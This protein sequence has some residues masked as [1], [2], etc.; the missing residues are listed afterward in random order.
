MGALG[1]TAVVGLAMV[2]G[3]FLLVAGLARW[4]IIAE[5]LSE[6]V[7]KGFLVGVGLTVAIG[8]VDANMQKLIRSELPQGAPAFF[9]V[10]IGLEVNLR[11]I[12]GNAWWFAIIITVVAIISKI[13][14]CGAGGLMSG[15][16]RKESLRLG[17]GMVSRDNVV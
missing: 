7:L 2:A 4:G 9:F 3:F 14:G 11:D 10:D 13:I 16:N 5:I 6:P 8:Q 17:I 1:K 15:F 12:S